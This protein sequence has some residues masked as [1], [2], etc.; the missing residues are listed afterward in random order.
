MKKQKRI[1]CPY[2]I[3]ALTSKVRLAR[4][5]LCKHPNKVEEWIKGD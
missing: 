4:H 2:C 5:V 1:Q 3:D